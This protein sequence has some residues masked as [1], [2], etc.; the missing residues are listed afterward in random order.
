MPLNWD[1]VYELALELHRA[2]PDADLQDVTLGQVRDWTIAL[3]EFLDDADLCND[4]I[5]HSIYQEWYEVTI[6]D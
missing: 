4:E 5:L 3:P 6:D 2:H 1:S